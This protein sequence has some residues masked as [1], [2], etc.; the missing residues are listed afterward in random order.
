MY[1]GIFLPLQIVCPSPSLG[2]S[3]GASSALGPRVE[4]TMPSAPCAHDRSGA[5][6][7]ATWMRR[8]ATPCVAVCA[9]GQAYGSPE[10]G[11]P[12]MFFDRMVD[13]YFWVASRPAPV[14]SHI[15]AR[16]PD[17]M[18]STVVYRC[19]ATPPVAT[20]GVVWR[21]VTMCDSIA[22]ARSSRFHALTH[23]PGS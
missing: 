23:L 4:P 11:S 8:W 16:C 14:H 1:I 6:P 17:Q 15:G 12:Q 5:A 19:C 22:C 3:S 18:R 2:S 7:Y 10:E 13:V 9:I 21:R 20:I